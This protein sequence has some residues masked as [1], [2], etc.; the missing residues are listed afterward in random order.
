MTEIRKY[1]RSVRR[2]VAMRLSVN[3][4][5]LKAIMREVSEIRTG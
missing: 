3:V 1:K 2:A 5:S 4:W